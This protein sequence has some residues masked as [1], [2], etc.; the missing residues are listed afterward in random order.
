MEKRDRRKIQTEL[1]ALADGRFSAEY[2]VVRIAAAA[3]A[4]G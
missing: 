1:D 2:P 4:K 3:E